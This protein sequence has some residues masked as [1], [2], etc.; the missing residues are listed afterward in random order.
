[1]KRTS[2][3]R[4]ER[5]VALILV[6]TALLGLMVLAVPFLEI[7]RHEESASVAP[8]ARAEARARAEA[9]L[10]YGAYVLEAGHAAE[11]A[12]RA[13]G[14]S[15]QGGRA[16]D[17]PSTDT[18]DESEV[19]VDLLDEKGAPAVDASGALL[20]HHKDSR[21]AIVDLRV[22]DDQA[23]P[24]LFSATPFLLS[25]TLGRTVLGKDM[26]ATDTEMRVEDGSFLR[27]DGGFVNLDGEVIGYRKRVG[28]LLTELSRGLEGGRRP[29]NHSSDE[30]VIDDRC[31]EIAMLP[32]KSPRA[33]GAWR[34]PMS[35]AYVKEIVLF[36]RDALTDNEADKLSD[37]FSLGG[38][39]PQSGAFGEKVSVLDAIDPTTAGSNGFPLR[40]SSIAGMNAGSLVRVSDGAQTEYG[41]VISARQQGGASGTITLA[42]PTKGS[43]ELGRATVQPLLRHPVNI[44]AAPHAVLLRLMEGIQLSYFGRPR[45]SSGRVTSEAAEIVA[46]A[47]ESARPVAGLKE[48]RSLLDGLVES[49][50]FIF[51]PIMAEAVF[52]NAVDAGDPILWASTQPFC[53]ESFDHYTMDVSSVVN[54]GGGRELARTEIRQRVHVAPRGTLSHLIDSQHDFED[55]VVRAR[56]GRW[57]V[58]FPYPVE[59]WMSATEQP[60][61]RM[62]RMLWNFGDGLPMAQANRERPE[63]DDADFSEGVFPSLDP[64]AGFVK[65]APGRMMSSGYNKHFDGPG[66]HIDEP[67]VSLARIDADGWRLER[68]PFEMDPR[69]PVGGYGGGAQS[70]QVGGGQRPRQTVSSGGGQSVSVQV[71]VGGR[72]GG[73]RGGSTPQVGNGALM[74]RS[75]IYPARFDLWYRFG[76]NSGGRH[77]LFDYVGSDPNDARIQLVRES[78]GSLVGRLSDRTIDD[79]ADPL[80]EELEVRWLPQDAGFWRGRTWYHL[81]LAY[82]GARPDDLMLFADGYRRGTP[83]Y[84]THLVAGFDADDT[85]FTVEKADGWPARGVAMV[86]SEVIAFERTGEDFTVVQLAGQPWGRAQRGSKALEHASGEPVQLFG[87]ST[88]PMTADRGNGVA[89]PRG[90][91]NLRGNLGPMRVATFQP[92]ATVNLTIQGPGGVPIPIPL[93]VHDPAAQGGGMLTLMAESG[94]GADFS[95]FPEA[96]GYVLIVSQDVPVTGAPAGGLE[97]ARYSARVGNQ[98]VGLTDAGNSVN[99]NLAGLPLQG[100][101]GIPGFG[102]TRRIHPVALAGT[103]PVQAMSTLSC[104]FPIS[105]ALTDVSG[106]AQPKIVAGGGGGTGVSSAWHTDPEFVQ[107]AQ[108]NFTNL[109]AHEVEWIRYHHVDPQGHLIMDEARYL[110][111]AGLILRGAHLSPAG[112]IFGSHNNL[113]LAMPFRL[114]GQTATMS[115][116]QHADG[117]E[118]VPCFRSPSHGSRNVIVN[119][120]WTP[121]NPEAPV[122]GND[123][124]VAGWGDSVTIEDM[125]GRDRMLA[126]VAWSG[127]DQLYTW[128][129]GPAGNQVSMQSRR[130]Y[131]VHGWMALS[132]STGRVFRQRGAPGSGE[133]QTRTQYCRL[134]KF[135]SGEL[136]DFGA[137]AR[138]FAGG[139]MDGGTGAPD[140]YVD[141]LRV[142]SFS[143]Q[144]YVLWNHSRMDFIPAAAGSPAA[145]AAQ[146]GATG[147]DA[148]T[149]EIPLANVR[150]VICNPD[151]VGPQP[152]FYILPDGRKIH[153]DEQLQGLPRNDAGLVQIG[154]EIIAFRRVGQG[155]DGEPALLDCQRGFMQTMPAAHGWGEEVVYLDFINVGQ[156]SG[157]VDAAA[158]ELPVSS[159]RGFYSD[160]GTVLIEDEMVHYS[161]LG[162]N[163]LTMPWA[164]NAANEP[165]AGL[166]RGRFGTQPAGHAQGALVLEMPFR[167]WDRYAARQD[168][169]EQTYYGF[170]LDLPGAFFRDIVFDERKTVEHVDLQVLART[171]PAIP[172]TADPAATPGLFLFDE[173]TLENP[174]VIRRSGRGLDVRV[175]FRY[176]PGAFNSTLSVH[177]WKSS[178]E[179]HSLRVNYMDETRVASREELR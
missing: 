6:L 42:E 7:A 30:V 68:G 95:C 86:G 65:L 46:K 14:A 50:P 75:T 159:A 100:G 63:K 161:Q 17:T 33:A 3:R 93:Q 158:A 72:P 27:E 84:K 29:G 77:V 28:N 74:G 157:A 67:G 73:G 31:R 178:V 131:P 69:D 5:G 39:R 124:S 36:G 61:S 21:G 85:N 40:V 82:R 2:P 164:L 105:I 175:L 136:P 78:D 55:T 120:N 140:G 139:D 11:E 25:A 107:L 119:Q 174:G 150:W 165:E 52:R 59:R 89:I 163:G 177:D 44:N 110:Y 90:G 57:I 92:N 141:E 172:W 13:Q 80:T 146:S 109:D 102:V 88:M 162:P 130:N 166:L 135:P 83:K 47:I 176:L 35:P 116:G 168:S 23:W 128:N 171:D 24:S 144:R 149:D 64:E 22:R 127:V 87:Y 12:T 134:L 132:E 71:Q 15:S 98:L 111:G 121:T 103:G 154:E 9:T 115:T 113:Q 19:P 1:M 26:T 62:L 125:N 16:F 179:L 79:P 123:L 34:E 4:A 51:T 54:D 137:N 133:V 148:V 147:I 126:K 41:Y 118:V 94:G 97:V 155:A 18:A 145:P 169:G 48:F 117:S 153:F 58:T 99:P 156:L 106:Y 104:V 20:F 81:G 37:Q 160:G 56:S 76:G 114:Q 122:A 91:G 112:G 8:L 10:R 101:N 108:V 66:F 45:G 170:S 151:N 32:F 129:F 53:F 70:T 173:G 167:H 142:T 49:W 38:R 60:V 138:A 143:A 43:Y 96:G 152:Q